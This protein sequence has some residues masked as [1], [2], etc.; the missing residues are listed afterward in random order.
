MTDLDRQWANSQIEALVDGSLPPEAERRMRQA[1]REDESLREQVDDAAV[2]KRE[3]KRLRR[4]RVPRGLAL[5]LAGIPVADRPR[6]L[7]LIPAAGIASLAAVAISVGVFSVMQQESSEAEA[8]AAIRDFQV[9]MAYLQ[10]STAL[11]QSE[12]NE[13]VSLALRDAVETSRG[14][15]YARGASNEGEQDNAD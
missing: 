12:M 14:A 6:G 11:A 15:L 13:A 5:R 7:R 4:V 10:K 1:M 2:L 8:R 9:A 3:L